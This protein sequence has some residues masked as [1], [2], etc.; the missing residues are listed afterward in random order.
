MDFA[1]SANAADHH[2]RS[3]PPVV[4]ELRAAAWER[5]RWNLF[6]PAESGLTNLECARLAELTGGGVEPV[7]EALDCSAPAAG[8]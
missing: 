2:R 1:T 8:T 6:L 3:V 4:E 7:G 5:G